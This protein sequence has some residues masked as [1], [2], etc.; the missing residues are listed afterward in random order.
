MSGVVIVMDTET[1]YIR[2]K[3][4]ALLEKSLATLTHVLRYVT[5]EQATT[6]RDGE[7]GWTTL[8][9]LCHLRDFD[10]IFYERAQSIMRQDEPH[11]SS[12]DPDA[13]AHERD[14]N[15][16][17]LVDVYAQLAQSRAQMVAFFRGL[18]DE[19]W[20]RVGIHPTNGRM[21][22]LRQLV[23]AAHHDCD[24]IEQI[25]RVLLQRQES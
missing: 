1:A 16:Q 20:Q 17:S 7:D 5:P 13:M 4:I 22:L 24:H 19:D 6:Y 2:D 9:I 15:A 23:Q 8:E 18:D 12:Y 14:Y 10:A 3:H 11:F 21:S 25:T